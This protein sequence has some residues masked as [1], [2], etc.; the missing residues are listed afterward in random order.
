MGCW[1]SGRSTTSRTST[2]STTAMSGPGWRKPTVD[3]HFVIISD[4]F[5][6]EAAQELTAELNGKYR[7]GAVL[8]SQL[9]VLPSYT[10]LGM[11]SLLPHKSLSYKG[12]DVLVDGHASAASDRDGI[13]QGVG[14]M[15]CKYDELMAKKKEEGREFIKDKRVVYIYH[16]AVDAIGD[17]SKTEGHTFE[18][19]RKAINELTALVGYIVNSLNGHHILVTADHGFL[20]TETARVETDK[21]K[22]NDKPDNAVFAKKRYLLAPGL[23]D[24]DAAWHGKT[25]VTAKADGDM[26]FWIPKGTNLFHFVGGARFVHGGAMPQEIVVPVVT[27]KHVRGKSAQ[28][29]KTKPVTVQVL[30]SNHRITSAYCRFQLIQMEAVSERLKQATLRV[31]VYEGRGARNRRPDRQVRQRFRKPRRAEEVGQ[32]GPEGPGLQQEDTVPAG[33]EGRGNGHR[34]AECGSCNRQGV[35]R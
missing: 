12:A 3:G 21:S 35:H 15:A 5:R 24:H 13:L 18:A 14:G 6:Y 29:T 31:A 34:A 1:R 9:G 7:F 28:E 4:A 26:D 27:V 22:L 33:P 2:V 16:D 19:V 30:G 10:A 8:S 17:D 20:F 11:A 23:P 32:P 25:S